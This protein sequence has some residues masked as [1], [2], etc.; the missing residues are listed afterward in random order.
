MDTASA[1]Q[2]YQPPSLRLI[3][4][5]HDLTEGNLTG[6]TSDGVLLILKGDEGVVN[7]SG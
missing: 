2:G 4:S 5:V 7:G 1:T 3:G 6:T